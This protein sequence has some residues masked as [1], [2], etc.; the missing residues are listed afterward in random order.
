MSMRTNCFRCRK[1]AFAILKIEAMVGE[2]RLKVSGEADEMGI[3]ASCMIE[4]A[5][6][7]KMRPGDRRNGCCGDDPG[8]GR[9]YPLTRQ[10]GL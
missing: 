3:C 2:T 10:R 1:P 6:F 5:E 4:L 7:F 9:D 8:I